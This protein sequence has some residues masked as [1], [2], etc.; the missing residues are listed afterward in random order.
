MEGFKL[1]KLRNFN[2]KSVLNQERCVSEW[3][4]QMRRH[5]VFICKRWGWINVTVGLLSL[6]E[7][8]GW[9]WQIIHN[10]NKFIIP[11]VHVKMGW[12]LYHSYNKINTPS[13]LGSTSPAKLFDNLYHHYLCSALLNHEERRNDQERIIP[14]S[15]D[16]KSV[17]N[18]R[19]CV[20]PLLTDS[21]SISNNRECVIPLLTDPKLVSIDPISISNIL[22]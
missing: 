6:H 19:E 17:A 11:F 21:K 20:I 14:F 4:V 3:S 18:N 22:A 16:P 13:Q 5:H 1:S 12:F 2:K 8:V 7:F 9:P 15:T 10:Q